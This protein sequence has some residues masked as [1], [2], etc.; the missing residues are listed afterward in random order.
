MRSNGQGLYHTC[1]IKKGLL[2]DFCAVCVHLCVCV[3]VIY[4]YMCMHECA[5]RG[6]MIKEDCVLAP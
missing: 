1:F 6:K 5:C 3:Y 4:A 2:Y